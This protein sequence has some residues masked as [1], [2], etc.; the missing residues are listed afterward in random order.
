MI[1]HT[2]K[3]K[4]VSFLEGRPEFHNSALTPEQITAALAELEATLQALREA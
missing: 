2:V 1:A 3:V 4:G